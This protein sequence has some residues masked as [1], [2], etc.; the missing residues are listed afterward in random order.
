MLHSVGW[1]DN[2][3]PYSMV[4]YDE[5]RARPAVAELQYLIADA[6]DHENYHLREVPIA[7]ENDHDINDERPRPDAADLPGARPR[8][9]GRLP[10]RGRATRATVPRA[11]W[12]LGHDDWRTSTTWPPPGARELRLY[13]GAAERAASG[14]EGG[15]L[16]AA[17]EASRATAHWV[18]D[19][20]ELV[21]STPLNPFAFLLYWP[22]ER[23]VQS[24]GD[25]L[26]FT[27]EP[28]SEPLDL[29]GPATAHL[30]VGSSFSSMH[31]MRQALRR[32]PRRGG[33]HA[34][35]AASGSCATPTRAPR[36]HPARATPAIVC[37]PVTA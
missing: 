16:L 5:L 32:R 29:T 31:V 13:L 6:T 7:P 26:T 1:F 19:P 4:D 24:R 28:M 36:R 27:S 2:I 10:A 3:L 35:R 25:V 12:F 14:P 11:A 17:P 21:P 18:H 34:A 37:Y 8:L 33:A 15:A 23:E 9:L 22:D 30:A 20:A